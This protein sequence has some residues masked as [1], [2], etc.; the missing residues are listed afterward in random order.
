MDS[1]LLRGEQKSGSKKIVPVVWLSCCWLLQT[2]FL[3][4]QMPWHR[5]LQPRHTLMPLTMNLPFIA[6]FLLP[7]PHFLTSLLF[8]LQ[9]SIIVCRLHL[10]TKPVTF[11]S[12]QRRED[13]GPTKCSLQSSLYK[14][15]DIGTGQGLTC[16]S[17]QAEWGFTWSPFIKCPQ[18][19]LTI[20]SASSPW[21]SVKQRE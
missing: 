5:I 8:T 11:H 17:S 21:S 1:W 15:S 3:C 12:F 19:T 4:G 13:E 6:P 7:P 14:I 18:V 9:D 10:P 20:W 2:K 16:H